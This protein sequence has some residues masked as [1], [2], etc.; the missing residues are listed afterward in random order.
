MNPT[1]AWFSALA[2]GSKLIF[3]SK[4]L[5]YKR[6]YLGVK[7]TIMGMSPDHNHAIYNFPIGPKAF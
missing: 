6:A 2:V 3:F 4:I 7:I 5:T 1:N